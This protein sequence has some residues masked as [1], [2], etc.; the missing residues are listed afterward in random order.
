M[1]VTV[2]PVLESDPRRLRCFATEAERLGFDLL[3]LGYQGCPLDFEPLTAASALSGITRKIGLCAAITTALGE[4]F[5]VARG[6][7]ALD[8]LSRGRA[9][10]QVTV[11][12]PELAAPYAQRVPVTEAELTERAAEFVEV[13]FA[14]WASWGAD[15]LIFDKPTADFSAPEQVHP[16]HHA[17]RFFRV[18]G[19]LNTP[20]PPQ[21]RPVV[22]QTSEVDP[23]WAS[24][25]AD[26]IVLRE[27]DALPRY[28]AQAAAAGRPFRLLL[29]APAEAAEARM[30]WASANGLDGIHVLARYGEL[31]SVERRLLAGGGT[32]RER[33][34]LGP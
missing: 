8:H 18:R 28:R 30:E 4:P 12:P 23:I 31:Q 19:P 21:G 9:G 10:W 29:E 33:L 11:R 14:L 1:I 7:A 3:L 20:R 22:I 15:A 17:G 34:G 2:S 13:V 27:P 25:T 26:I 24:R 16:I 32:L 6:L 5:T